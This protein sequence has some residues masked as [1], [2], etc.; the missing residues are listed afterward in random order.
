ML[1]G[2]RPVLDLK[3]FTVSAGE[4]TI[5]SSVMAGGRRGGEDTGGGPGPSQKRGSGS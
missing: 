2:G 1:R 4:K 3:Q 5:N